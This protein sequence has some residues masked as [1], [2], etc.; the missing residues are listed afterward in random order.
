MGAIRVIHP[1]RGSIWRSSSWS[2]GLVLGFL[3]LAWVAR[4]SVHVWT[5]RLAQTISIHI[6]LDSYIWSPLA[7]LCPSLGEL[8]LVEVGLGKSLLWALEVSSG[9]LKRNVGSLYP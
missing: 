2:V 9:H 8:E 6:P 4:A 7:L 1:A 5:T 3:L